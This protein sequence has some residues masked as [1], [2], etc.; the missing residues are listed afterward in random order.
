[1]QIAKDCTLFIGAGGSM[2]RERAILGIPY[3]FCLPD[4]L[5]EVDKFLLEN[6]SHVAMN[7][8]S[9]QKK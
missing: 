9:R 4:E 3:N 8:I 6:G 5:L 2:T 7:Q 1:M